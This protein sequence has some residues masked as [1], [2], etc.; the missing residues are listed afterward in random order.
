VLCF[1][2]PHRRP[3]PRLQPFT[4]DIFNS[5]KQFSILFTG[6]KVSAAT[7]TLPTAVRSEGS[8]L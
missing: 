4:A 7:R 5:L 2:T 3:R 8:G 6:P 1:L